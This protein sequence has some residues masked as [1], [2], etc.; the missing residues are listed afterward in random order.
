MRFVF[1][2]GDAMRFREADH[3]GRCDAMELF[4]RHDAMRCDGFQKLEDTGRCD[5]MDVRNLKARDDA[6][7]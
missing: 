4:K 6:M 3:A 7:R 5:A 1:T 2:R